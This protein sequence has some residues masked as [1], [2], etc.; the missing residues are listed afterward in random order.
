MCHGNYKSWSMLYLHF[1]F[2]FFHVHSSS[3]GHNSKSKPEITMYKLQCFEIWHAFFCSQYLNKFVVKTEKYWPFVNLLLVSSFVRPVNYY[4][5]NHHHD[6]YYN[7]N[8]YHCYYF[9]D[10]FI[11]LSLSSPSLSSSSSSILA[12][13]FYFKIKI[14][15]ISRIGN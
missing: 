4:Y 2:F 7:N 12:C 15:T 1:F 6:H 8:D 10:S 3:T 5:I 14:I 11:Y 13:T 9:H